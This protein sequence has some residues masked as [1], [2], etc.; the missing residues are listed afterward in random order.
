MTERPRFRPIMVEQLPSLPR[1]CSGCAL[2]EGVRPG[3]EADGNAAKWARAA[4]QEWGL[5]GISAQV[6]AELAGYLLFCPPL[7]V[8][9]S[10]P[11]GG[12]PHG[13]DAAAMLSIRVQ[14]ECAGVGIGRQL[15]QATAARAVRMGLAALEVRATRVGPSCA[16]PPV[17]FLTATGFEITVAHPVHPRLRLDLARTVRWRPGLLNSALGRLGDWVRPLPPEPASRVEP[18]AP[19]R[20]TDA[21]QLIMEPAIPVK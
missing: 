15:I 11:Q 17:G 7:H 8:P 12:G 10:G 21:H 16:L 20:W 14:P 5:C 3:L 1:T 6:G 4:Q 9:R 13:A 19:T 18:A 2:G